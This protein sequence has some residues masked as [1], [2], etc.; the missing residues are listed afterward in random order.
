MDDIREYIDLIKI[1][2]LLINEPDILSLFEMLI[3]II[4]NRL[5]RIFNKS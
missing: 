5:N 4:N 3:I 1:R 2:K